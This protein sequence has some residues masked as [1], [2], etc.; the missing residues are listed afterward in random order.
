MPATIIS[1]ILLFVS[2]LEVFET[3]RIY[4]T[5]L[6]IAL[7]P[8]LF[9]VSLCGWR[10]D[11]FQ[12]YDK[13]GS[14]IFSSPAAV[15]HKFYT[16]YIH[17]VELTPVEDDYIVVDGKLWSWEER[18]RS[19]K[20]GMPSMLPTQGRFF[21]DDQWMTY[22]GGR[23]SWNRYYYRIGDKRFGL[24]Q[25]SF[26][27]FGRRNIFSIYPG[28]CLTVK[29]GREPFLYSSIYRSRILAQAPS[30]VPPV[31]RTDAK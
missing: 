21:E 18:V 20:A 30:G 19:S 10:V 22:Q 9:A 8:L 15:G 31:T 26:E 12:I 29:I 3:K 16:R 23:I 6:T 14:L 7:L 24:N 5:A 4:G 25:A 2:N 27:P 13:K 11:F 1:V 17:S 28:Q